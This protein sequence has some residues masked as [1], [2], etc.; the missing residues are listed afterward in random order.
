MI[1]PLG[2]DDLDLAHDLRR[3]LHDHHAGL[4]DVPG[5]RQRPFEQAWA[6]W[7]AGV[8]AVLAADRGAVFV[9]VA[10]DSSPPDGLVYLHVLESASLV[11]PM[12]EPTGPHVELSTLVVAESARGTGV[13]SALSD[14]G[15]AWA[16]ERGAVALQIRVRA[17]NVDALR[18]YERRGAV[19]GF[20]T[21]VQPL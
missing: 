17:S 14:A 21:L 5:Y 4:P 15:N 11:R 12:V 9:H 18:L 7:R 1:R 16:R 6:E 19:R 20:D 3:A 8:A 2:V 13:G 10:D